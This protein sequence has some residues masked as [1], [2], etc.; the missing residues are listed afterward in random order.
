MTTDND[1]PRAERADDD[2]VQPRR[3]TSRDLDAIAERLASA[4][5][6]TQDDRTA[7]QLPES[8]ASDV[9]RARDVE[10]LR[11]LFVRTSPD[12]LYDNE[13][14][15]ASG[16]TV[17]KFEAPNGGY[18]ARD[19]ATSTFALD[20]DPDTTAPAGGAL[21]FPRA[22]EI[23]DLDRP[24]PQRSSRPLWRSLATGGVIA[25]G[26]VLAIGAYAGGAEYISELLDD[27]AAERAAR[28]APATIDAVVI[29]SALTA[30]DS[31]AYARE[32]AAFGERP[33]DTI[34]RAAFGTAR[35]AAT[36][37][38]ATDS[39]RVAAAS[40][41][42]AMSTTAALSQPA[43]ASTA[44]DHA[45]APDPVATVAPRFT[46]QVRATPDR[47]EAHRIATQLRSRGARDVTITTTTKNGSTVYRVRYGSFETAD[48]ARASARSNGHAD[49]WAVR[50]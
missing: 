5:A 17:A 18:D 13:S 46:V 33:D 38:R 30:A 42:R 31:I 35:I 41:R 39:A 32:L 47:T 16:S 50:H 19:N 15:A 44:T 8:E 11:R 37:K 7:D 14:S 22:D 26:F 21:Q 45:S 34:R 29:D 27:D 1:E 9:A 4:R 20:V 6:A 10:R 43:S 36:P 40:D 48:A 2:D 25:L 24:L 12:E 23:A 49:A 3:S 28:S